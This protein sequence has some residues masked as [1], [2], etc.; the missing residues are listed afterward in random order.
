MAEQQDKESWGP[1]HCGIPF[2]A[3]TCLYLDFLLLTREIALVTVMRLLLL[4]AKYNS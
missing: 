2:Q 1:E 4:A 3:M